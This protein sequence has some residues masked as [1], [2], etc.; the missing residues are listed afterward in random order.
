MTAIYR[1]GHIWLS[2]TSDP[3]ND[4]QTEVVWQDIKPNSWPAGTPSVFQSGFINGTGTNPWTYMPSINV[5]AAGDAAIT[6]TQSSATECPAMYYVSRLATAPLGTFEAPVLAKSSVGFYNSFLADAE[7]DPDRWGDYSATV[8]D[9]TDDCFW[10]ANEFVF[11]S[12]VDTSEWGTFIASFC[13]TGT[14]PP[15]APQAAAAPYD[16]RKHRFVSI[17]ASTNGSTPVALKVTLN[18]LLR[19]SNDPQHRAGLGGC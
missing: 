17:D 16:V 12:G 6:Y 11:S 13:T 1:D 19:C 9:P 10:V 18:S 5:T 8:V 2:L 7:T 3:D 4:G 15:E 14:P